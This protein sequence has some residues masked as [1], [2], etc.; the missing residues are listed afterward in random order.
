MD[1]QRAAQNIARHY[2]H[3]PPGKPVVI[4]CDE[5]KIALARAV[6]VVLEA[7]GHPTILPILDGEVLAQRRALTLLLEEDSIALAVF[8]SFRMWKD[9]ALSERITQR[10]HQPSLRGRPEPL[11]FDAVI[12]L[13]SL[14]RL[15][16]ADPKSIH[17][18]Q[19]GLQS[20]LVNNTSVH[21]TT[22][23]GVDLR[24]LA[25]TWQPWGWELMTCPV[26]GSIHGRIVVDGAVLF[27]RTHQPIEL[28]ITN[29]KL[30]AMDCPDRNDEV[31]QGYRQWMMEVMEENP[32]NAQ[33]CEVGLGANPNAQLSDVLMET[34]AVQGVAYF[35]FGDNASFE[36][37]G[38]ANRTGWHGGTATVQQSR[39]V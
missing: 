25:R 36:G 10:E 11:F 28:I 22:P 3:P 6:A 12:P 35:C 24:F 8:A 23:A 4:A 31:F 2:F 26:E 18:F 16:S 13:E 32:A 5:E 15:Y 27:G 7:D 33:L 19:S 17:S 20:N 14:L 38:G 1:I 9:L 34:E 29:G 39:I 21:L 37:M 30:S